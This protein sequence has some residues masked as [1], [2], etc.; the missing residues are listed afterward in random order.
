MEK[1]NLFLIESN[2]TI[3]RIRDVFQQNDLGIHVMDSATTHSEALD[4]LSKQNQIDI[5][6][7][8]EVIAE[9]MVTYKEQF[10]QAKI[11]VMTDRHT[12]KLPIEAD[13]K[14]QKPFKVKVLLD[15]IE[16]I[17]EKTKIIPIDE[18]FK[19]LADPTRRK[20]LD[21]LR[22]TTRTA[23]EI[24]E[25]C[26]GTKPN[27]SQHLKVLKNSGLITEEKKGL[28]VYY[29]LSQFDFQ[30][31]KK[32]VGNVLNIKEKILFDIQQLA[33]KKNC[34]PVVGATDSQDDGTFYIMKDS[35]TLISFHYSFRLSSFFVNFEIP[36]YLQKGGNYHIRYDDT[37][38]IEEFY[39]S[40]EEELHQH[41]R[42]EEKRKELREKVR[43]EL[44]KYL[45]EKAR[46]LQLFMTKNEKIRAQLDEWMNGFIEQHYKE[47]L[48][49]HIFTEI[50]SDI[51]A[52]VSSLGKLHD[53]FENPEISEIMVNAPD[54]VWIEQKGKLIKTAITFKDEDEVFQLARKIAGYVGRR[55]DNSQPIL[56]T[57]LPDGSLVHIMLPPIAVRGIN[58]VIRKFFT[59]KLTL[60]DLKKFDTISEDASDFLEQAVAAR[61]NILVSGGTGAGKTTSL[62]I[63]AQLI[64]SDERIV[65]IEDSAELQL[66]QEHVVKIE[67]RPANAE[68][69]GEINLR[70]CLMAGMK[71]RPDRLLIG[72][73][74]DGVAH[75]IIQACL[76]GQEGLMTSV[77]ANT[78][79]AALERL[80]HLITYAGYDYPLETIQQSI[81]DAFD[82][83]VQINRLK[84]GSR[85]I[86][87]IAQVVGYDRRL[88]GLLVLPLFKWKE[89]GKEHGKLTGQFVYTGYELTEKLHEKFDRMNFSNPFERFQ[90]DGTEKELEELEN[91]LPN[92]TQSLANAMRSGHILSDA[93]RFVHE[94]D[95][96]ALSKHFYS[97][98]QHTNAGMSQI[99]ALLSLRGKINSPNLHLLLHTICI[100]EEVGGKIEPLLRHL[101][102]ILEE[103]NELLYGYTREQKEARFAS[104]DWQWMEFLDL[105]SEIAPSS[106]SLNEAFRKVHLCLKNHF[107][108]AFHFATLEMDAGKTTKGALEDTAKRLNHEDVMS[109]VKKL[110]ASDSLG[111][112][113]ES[114][115]REQATKWRSRMKNK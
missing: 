72:E 104:D 58:I 11:I 109:F 88:K 5:I 94:T 8:D 40:I 92:F 69:I 91:E 52:E 12:H 98:V 51:I 19:A 84:D 62:N 32:E 45:S 80:Q 35:E 65:T 74:R 114:T 110:I 95:K 4:K 37:K 22:N 105:L 55:I 97:V 26:Q 79:R 59:E 87:E 36:V 1:I 10:P 75:D 82:L 18:Q 29:S 93:L 60:E 46:N 2:Q 42:H 56:H 21:Y 53:V 28:Y 57:R 115:I 44:M 17:T 90:E 23:G 73:I 14:L 64:P 99:E 66:K 43:Y 50:K 113:V 33:Y 25:F 54:D 81:G 68:G 9:H 48:P 71:L 15:T 16:N 100:Q 111:T 89:K 107:S 67:T 24:A 77:H 85:K 39:R 108:E 83:V 49:L 61:A 76:T 101:T 34:E 3:Q 20:I 31:A 112:G 6:L 41:V 38:G 47:Q 70:S 103:R 13:A 7:T 102:E 30:Q 63:L 27:I 106:R 86:T 78:V 96:T